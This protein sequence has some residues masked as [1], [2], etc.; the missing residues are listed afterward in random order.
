MTTIRGDMNI[1]RPTGVGE[2]FRHHIQR[3]DT[4]NIAVWIF[5]FPDIH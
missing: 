2:V 1:S 3:L 4:F 5:Q